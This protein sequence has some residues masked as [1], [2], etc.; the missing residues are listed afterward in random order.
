MSIAL[1]ALPTEDEYATAEQALGKANDQIERLNWR[2]REV[3]TAIRAGA[4]RALEVAP[5]Y[6]AM[7]ELYSFILGARLL[8]EQ[9]NVHV[10]A[11]TEAL[12]GLDHGRLNFASEDSEETA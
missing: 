7:G 11:L 9:I 6:Q 10:E 8:M 12:D 1:T 3:T 4:W 5:T 2:V